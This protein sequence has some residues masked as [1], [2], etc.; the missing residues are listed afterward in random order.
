MLSKEYIL[1]LNNEDL[2]NYLYGLVYFQFNKPEYKDKFTVKKLY[3]CNKEVML[4]NYIGDYKEFN[5]SDDYKLTK[6]IEYPQKQKKKIKRWFKI[7]PI[8]KKLIISDPYI[9]VIKKYSRFDKKAKELGFLKSPKSTLDN[10][11]EVFDDSSGGFNAD[12]SPMMLGPVID[13]YGDCIGYNIEDAWQGS[14]V[15]TFHM[16]GG[17]FD[18]KEKKNNYWKNGNKKLNP[19]GDKWIEEWKKWSEF[20]RFSGEGLRRRCKIETKDKCINPNIPLFSYY[21]GKR[22]SYVEARKQMYI[23]W[24]AD[25]VIKTRSFKYLK[26]RFDKGISLIILD[27]D[28]QARDTKIL[29]LNKENMSLKIN[30]SKFVFGHGFVLGCVILG[31]NVWNN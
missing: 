26:N 22:L 3:K 28:G 31:I 7:H 24:Y 23:P 5:Q 15:F 20:C 27:P 6:I 30:D 14:K 16:N 4:K 2:T 18:P 29:K 13:K 25:L 17:K 21:R 11:F 8:N 19:N 1:K 9:Q 10:P 12:L